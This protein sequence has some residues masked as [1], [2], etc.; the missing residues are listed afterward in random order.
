MEIY[1]LP[2]KELKINVLEK[3]SDLQDNTDRQQN[4]IW[5]TI[6]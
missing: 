2:N 4:E 1:K 3:F 5:K 6:H